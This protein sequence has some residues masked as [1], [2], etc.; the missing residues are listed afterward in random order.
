MSVSS[1]VEALDPSPGSACSGRPN[2]AR[3]LMKRVVLNT[4]APWWGSRT[5]YATHRRAGSS[6]PS[7]REPLS[8]GLHVSALTAFACN[9]ATGRSE[10]RDERRCIAT[11]ARPRRESAD[12]YLGMNFCEAEVPEAECSELEG[13]GG[14][15][16]KHPG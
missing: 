14:A 6:W 2:R 13:N 9:D 5:Y 10:S 11:L 8:S 4:S 1:E 16:P 7:S 3:A 15:A 12:R